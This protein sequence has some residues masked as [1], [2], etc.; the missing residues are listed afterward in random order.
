MN[1]PKPLKTTIRVIIEMVIA[2]LL[3]FFIAAHSFE[4]SASADRLMP[5]TP[6]PEPPQEAG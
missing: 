5:T 6:M 4:K 1:H 2:S 3:F